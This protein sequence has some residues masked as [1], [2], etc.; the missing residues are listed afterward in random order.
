MRGT[1]G[2]ISR[3]IDLHGTLKSQAE[4]SEMNTGIK[5]VL[6]KPFDRLFKKKPAG[7]VVP[8]HLIGTY[9]DPQPGVDIPPK[10]GKS[11]PSAA[12]ER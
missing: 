8:V 6:L 12:P 3:K 5:S 1:Y 11:E 2:V 7:A 10:K 4:L 9:E